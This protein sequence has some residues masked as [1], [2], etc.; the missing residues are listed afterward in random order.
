MLQPV[1]RNGCCF[2]DALELLDKRHKRDNCDRLQ[3]HH[4]CNNNFLAF[5]LFLFSSV[6][7]NVACIGY[8]RH[9]NIYL[10]S[11]SLFRTKNKNNNVYTEEEL[12]QS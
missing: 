3:R 7:L 10:A 2:L 1:T 8:N 6:Q 11:N 9:Q 4:V 12:A 5:T